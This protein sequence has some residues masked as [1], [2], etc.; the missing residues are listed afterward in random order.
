MA[1]FAVFQPVLSEQQEILNRQLLQLSRFWYLLLF[2]MNYQPWTTKLQNIWLT[3]N[4]S[5]TLSIVGCELLAFAVSLQ[6]SLSYTI[7]GNKSL[8]F[9]NI[10]CKLSIF[11]TL[12]NLWLASSFVR[13]FRFF[14]TLII[15]IW[16]FQLSRIFGSYPH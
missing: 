16:S 1:V 6:E 14:S 10:D 2:V 4:Q 3:P 8:I 15:N 11:V 13:N 5:L 9:A 7:V 12:K